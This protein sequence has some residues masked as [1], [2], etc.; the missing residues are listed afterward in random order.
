[1]KK[2]NHAA[3]YQSRLRISTHGHGFRQAAFDKKNHVPPLLRSNHVLSALDCCP[4]LEAP[5]IAII[6]RFP[7]RYIRPFTGQVGETRRNSLSCEAR[8]PEF[9]PVPPASGLAPAIARHV[10]LARPNHTHRKKT[11]T[12]GALA[13]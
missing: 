5:C 13:L 10:A 9:I 3:C 2:A 6:D 1:A 12:N 11:V 7:R 4:H 8:P